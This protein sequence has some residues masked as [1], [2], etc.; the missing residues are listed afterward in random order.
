MMKLTMSQTN[1]DEDTTAVIRKANEKIAINIFSNGLR[2][3][4]I[5]TIIK[6]RKYEYIKDAI[7]DALEQETENAGQAHNAFTFSQGRKHTSTLNNYRTSLNDRSHTAI[8]RKPRYYGRM[9]DR[10]GKSTPSHTIIPGNRYN[11]QT[12]SNRTFTP[13]IHKGF[14]MKE[15][16]GND[17]RQPQEKELKFFRG[18]QG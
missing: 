3:R 17:R 18:L 14:T 12:R 5:R 7:N 10:T 4:D 6:A 16:E 2:Q 1:G 13:T 8:Q 15:S 9:N 11:K